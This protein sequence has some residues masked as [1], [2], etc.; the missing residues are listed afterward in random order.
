MPLAPYFYD[1]LTAGEVWSRSFTLPP[2]ASVDTWHFACY[3]GTS[4]NPVLTLAVTQDAPGGFTFTAF[5]DE[6]DTKD[7]TGE[8]MVEFRRTDA[9]Y[10]YLPMRGKVKVFRGV[11]ND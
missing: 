7:L 4:D 9:G 3:W 2:G 6:N 11:K 5:A 1:E 10:K 8:Y